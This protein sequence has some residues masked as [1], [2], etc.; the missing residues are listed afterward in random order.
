MDFLDLAAGRYS[1]RRFK[2]KPV[3]ERH[4][5]RILEA[6]RLAPTAHNY[7]PQEIIVVRSEEGLE[8][9][10][11]CTECHYHAPLAFIISY[12]RDKAWQRE[13]DGK[14]SGDVD[15]SIVTTHMMMEAASLGLGSTWVMY[16]IPEAVSCEFEL[17]DNTVPVAIL[18][19]GEPDMAPSPNHTK[20]TDPAEY[21]SYR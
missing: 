7:Q 21:V 6:A 12:R 1:V 14:C 16:F 10:R 5:E 19:V 18:L 2:T 20:R 4:I 8:K 17:S 9:L 11:R 3:D 13:Y 15:A